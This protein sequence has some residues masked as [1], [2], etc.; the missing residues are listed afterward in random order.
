V[1]AYDINVDIS[2]LLNTYYKS[3]QMVSKDNT[4][5]GY[6]RIEKI[7]TEDV[8]GIRELEQVIVDKVTE[9]LNSNILLRTSPRNIAILVRTNT[10]V[11]LFTRA[12][13]LANIPIASEKTLDISENALV[14]EIISFLVFL[15]APM[16]NLAF[17]SFISGSIF[18][19]A[20]GITQDEIFSFLLNTSTQQKPLY[21]LFRNKYNEIWDKYIKEYIH[22]VGFLP[23]YDLVSRI[24]KRY[25]I[26][27]NFQE[28]EGIF[29]QLLEVLRYSEI[30]CGNSLKAFLSLW[31]TPDSETKELFYVNLPE[32]ID[33]VK[34]YTIHKAKGLGFPIVIVPFP[35]LN[36]ASVN[37]VYDKDDMRLIPYRINQEILNVSPK[38]QQFKQQNITSQ[39]IDELNIFYVA[40]TR[41]KNE[42]YIFLPEFDNMKV[43]NRL[44]VP[45]S[46]DDTDIVEYGVLKDVDNIQKSKQHLLRRVHPDVINEWQTKLYRKCIPIEELADLE[47]KKAKEKGRLIHR[48][49]SMIERLSMDNWEKEIEDKFE[50]LKDNEKD[51]IPV[52]RNFFAND[53]IRTWFVVPEDVCV[54]CEKEVVDDTG[55][56][57]RIDRMLVS[58]DKVQL[59]EFKYKEFFLEYYESQVTN[60]LK[61]ISNIYPDKLIE[62]YLVYVDTASYEQ[63]SR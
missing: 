55:T 7:S 12:L 34:I 38:L 11:A 19:K 18:T 58:S 51:I 4:G 28:K 60:Y 13:T 40:L 47:K 16:D 21:I 23:P 35:Y 45:V 6:V 56:E 14:N 43:K 30:K 33:A 17:A 50:L 10:E 54:Y 15:D 1:N 61:I 57:Y 49:L 59:I 27:C 37:E 20:T 36:N 63:V 24:I 3:A 44:P 9:L 29:Y 52:I 41:A 5:N 25:N 2:L 42:L 46:I 26:F 32:Y 53:R 22:A 31:K 48:F 39:I 62:G 8:S